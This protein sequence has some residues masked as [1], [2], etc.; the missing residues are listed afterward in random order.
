MEGA[1]PTVSD[2]Q[3]DAAA[4]LRAYESTRKRGGS[5][6]ITPLGMGL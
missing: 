4:K 6:A 1:G 5:A 3:Q 2:L